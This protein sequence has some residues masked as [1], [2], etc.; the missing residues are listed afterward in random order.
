L[1]VVVPLQ[2]SKVF[3]QTAF[4]LST[5]SGYGLDG[6]VSIPGREDS[7]RFYTVSRQDL[8]PTQTPIHWATE[9]LSL[10]IKRKVREVSSEFHLPSFVV[11]MC[12]NIPPVPPHIFMVR[13]LT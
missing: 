3:S 12:R 2:L 7:F 4:S 8:G 6:C 5:V 10:W 13:C 1:Y 11:V 9:A